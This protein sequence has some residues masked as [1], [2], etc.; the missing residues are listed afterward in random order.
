VTINGVALNETSYLYPGSAPSATPFNITVPAGRL[1]V[2]GDHRQVSG[3]SRGHMDPGDPTGTIP[4]NEVIG[5]A[6]WIVWP[7][8]K[9]R[10]LPIP[11]TFE[12]PALNSGKAAA[13]SQA[14]GPDTISAR[15]VPAGPALPLVAAAIISSTG[16]SSSSSAAPSSPAAMSPA[17]GGSLPPGVMSAARA[18][19]ESAP[20]HTAPKYS[21]GPLTAASPSHHH[22]PALAGIAAS[23]QRCR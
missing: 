22:Q 1:W 17:P 10:V 21:N 20:E 6:F 7:P 9:W 11:A 15:I 8:G 5:R 13:S 19:R 14:A 4:E 2:M 23:L 3:D 16:L 18:C 12:Q